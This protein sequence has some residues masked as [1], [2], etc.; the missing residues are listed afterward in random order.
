[1]GSTNWP[2][3][4]FEGSLA[5]PNEDASSHLAP[6]TKIKQKEQIS[7]STLT[8][9]SCTEEAARILKVSY[10]DTKSESCSRGCSWPSSLSGYHKRI[11]SLAE[12]KTARKSKS[13]KE[14]RPSRRSRIRPT[15]PDLT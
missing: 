7:R 10:F 8:D 1:M 13:E 14:K 11:E 3:L 12:L 5:A 2:H 4:K 6:V 15:N 9:V